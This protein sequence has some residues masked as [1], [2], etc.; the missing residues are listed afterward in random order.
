MLLCVHAQIQKIFSGGTTVRPGAVQQI[1]PLQKSIFWKFEGGTRQILGCYGPASPLS[2][3]NFSTLYRIILTKTLVN[4]D[5]LHSI[6]IFPSKYLPRK[7][8][9]LRNNDQLKLINQQKKKK[10][11]RQA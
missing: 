10:K 2:I 7:K 3:C 5:Q 6:S 11:K 4:L 9:I 1:L 8:Y